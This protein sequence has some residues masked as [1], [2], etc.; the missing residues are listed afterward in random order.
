MINCYEVK[1]LSI[2]QIR[3]AR[4]LLGWTQKELADNSGLSV[5]A[6]NRLECEDAHPRTSTMNLIQLT[7]EKHGVIFFNERGYAGVK[8]REEVESS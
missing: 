2:K 4:G 5:R 3:A 6:I 7:L 1:M 8:I